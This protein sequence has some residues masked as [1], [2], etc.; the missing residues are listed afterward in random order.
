M[1]SENVSSGSIHAVLVQ[2]IIVS[3]SIY[4]AVRYKERKKCANVTDCRDKET[5]QN[6]QEI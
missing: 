1:L 2:E 5:F 3:I 4:S 6:S